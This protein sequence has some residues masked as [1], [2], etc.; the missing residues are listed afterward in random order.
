V[1]SCGEA[2]NGGSAVA[3]ATSLHPDLIVM[4]LVMPEING[5]EATRQVLKFNQKARVILTTLHEFPSS[6]DEVRRAG[7]C[8]L[9][10]QD[11]VR[12]ASH[13]GGASGDKVQEIFH[14]R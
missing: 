7:A 6:V 2:E 10:F 4:D 12:K 1:E 3:P 14:S 5:L 11:R 9:F 8:V 13:P